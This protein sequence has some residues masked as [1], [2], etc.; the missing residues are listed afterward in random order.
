ME[1][2]KLPKEILPLGVLYKAINHK[3]CWRIIETM[4]SFPNGTYSCTD[5]YVRLRLEPT[6]LSKHLQI[7]K[8]AN[9]VVLKKNGKFRNY[10]INYDTI[11]RLEKMIQ[12]L[13]N[14]EELAENITKDAKIN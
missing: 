7:L 2:N 8:R 11:K 14:K 12:I 4:N 9:L 5:L 6:E 3:L 10:S 13:N 1:L